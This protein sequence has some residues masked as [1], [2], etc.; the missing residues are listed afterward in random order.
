MSAFFDLFQLEWS[1]WLT[2]S[3]KRTLENNKF[4]NVIELPVTSDFLKV[5][6]YLER[7]I[8]DLTDKLKGNSNL[9]TWGKLSEV[10]VTQL[11]TFNKR[12]SAEPTTLLIEKF[13]ER[14]K[15][16]TRLNLQI[17]QIL[18]PIERTLMRKVSLNLFTLWALFRCSKLSIYNEVVQE[19]ISSV[20]SESKFL[21]FDLL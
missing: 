13:I 5:K 19:G 6:D 16:V 7:E 14:K 9:D 11:T 4:K 8:K 2:S 10:C 1:I 20:C 12:K 21:R 15:F 18:S 17:M 3:A